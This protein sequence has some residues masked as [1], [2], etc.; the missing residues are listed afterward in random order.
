MRKIRIFYLHVKIIITISLFII[1]NLLN[2]ACT[3]ATAEICVGAD[4]EAYVW[5]NGN[6]IDDGTH[7]EA[8]MVGETVPC[9][10]VP[11]A[12][13]DPLGNNLI[14]VQNNN[15]ITG[16]VWA[17]WALDITCAEG[18]HIYLKNTDDNNRYYDQPLGDP[19]PAAD[20]GGNAWYEVD[21]ADGATW[22][23]PYAVTYP[24]ALYDS[25]AVD[26]ETGLFL[27]P[28]SF[29]V[30]AGDNPGS[31]G[32]TPAGHNLFF[33]QVFTLIEPVPITKTINQTVF[34]IG[35]TVTYCFD[36]ENTEDAARSF[37]LWDT[38]PQE[39]DFVGCDNGCTTQTFGSDFVVNWSINVS[40]HG[41][42]T[43][44]VWAVVARYPGYYNINK[45]FF[46]L[47]SERNPELF[48]GRPK[49]RDAL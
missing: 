9:A 42:G 19:T 44:C 39:V 25:P 40:G 6:V 18:N 10:N 29:S 13:L 21:Y 11:V 26:P 4:D 5:I 45:N 46:A 22:D 20:A 7:F 27:T 35:D 34:S 3:P 16:F 31:P 47:L 38:L 36:Y 23:V 41:S 14:A 48:A 1:P 32:E 2:A 15:V 37:N 28:S 49:S 17:S 12:Y 43:V 8:V 33:R 24:A 30:N